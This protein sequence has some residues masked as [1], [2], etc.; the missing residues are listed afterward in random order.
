MGNADGVAFLPVTALAVN[1][2][3]TGSQTTFCVVSAREQPHLCQ[4][5]YWQYRAGQGRRGEEGGGAQGLSGPVRL[6]A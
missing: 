5:R 3:W 2:S 1:A 6:T 4:I